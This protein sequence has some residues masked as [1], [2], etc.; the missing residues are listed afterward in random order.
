MIGR[1]ELPPTNRVWQVAGPGPGV[2]SHRTGAWGGYQ[3][4]TPHLLESVK[5]YFEDA[6]FTLL[7]VCDM[8]QWCTHRSSRGCWLLVAGRGR[9]GA[10]PSP[11]SGGPQVAGAGPR[12]GLSPA[13]DPHHRGPAAASMTSP[14]HQSGADTTLSSSFNYT[15][16]AFL[17][18]P[19][20]T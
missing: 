14:L 8:V 12:C 2:T 18:S 4:Y 19:T 13:R 15:S 16:F 17:F 7:C 1:A 9:G 20:A 10:L 3:I 6:Y 11:L 5:T